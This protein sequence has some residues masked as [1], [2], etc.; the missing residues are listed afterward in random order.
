MTRTISTNYLTKAPRVAKVRENECPYCKKAFEH[1]RTLSTHMCVKKRRYA[2]AELTGNRLGFR[3]FQIFYQKN[4]TSKVPKSIDDFISSQYYT[5]FVKFGNHVA[6]LKP[7]YPEKF[8]DFVID[9]NIKL[10]EWTSDIV[11]YAY[12][13]HLLKTE[14]ADSAIERSITV[15][16]EW[17]EKR[18]VEFSTFFSS[19][20]ENECAF[21]ILTGKISPWMLYLSE[22]ADIVISKFN[23]DH[24][25]MIG[26]II[27]SS[28]WMKKFKKEESD[29]VYIRNI[30]SMAG[31]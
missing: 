12:I 24:S 1:L 22:T 7:I 23:K 21:M 11:Y 20:N 4:T 13:E 15:M 10:K 26:S 30:L 27:D 29:V 17:C 2:D 3:T 18:N 9:N 14:P 25:K 6:L 31:I 8:I 5:D 28:F 16:S 19:V